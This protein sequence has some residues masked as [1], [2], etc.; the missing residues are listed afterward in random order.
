MIG[1]LPTHMYINNN[2]CLLT[3]AL[4]RAHVLIPEHQDS[5]TSQATLIGF[6]V[7]YGLRYEVGF[8]RARADMEAT[9]R[10]AFGQEEKEEKTKER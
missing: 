7:F 8:R 4:S 2:P 5:T 10:N 6:L 1:R 9:R 3:R